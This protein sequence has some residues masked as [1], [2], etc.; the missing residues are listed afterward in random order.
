M[1]CS[2]AA[3]WM[4]AARLFCPWDSPG[5]NT[6]V[7]CYSLLQ[8]IFPTQGSKPGLLHCRHIL[9]CLSH[10]ESPICIIYRFYNRK[11]KSIIT[12]SETKFNTVQ[13]GSLKKNQSYREARNKTKN[14]TES[15]TKRYEVRLKN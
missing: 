1:S 4:V 3:P 13:L 6:G 9:Y 2:F 5:K 11:R 8:G 15:K 10:Q 14:K 7:G 12:Y